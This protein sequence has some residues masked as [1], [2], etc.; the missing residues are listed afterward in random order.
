MEVKIL[1]SALI[2]TSSLIIYFEKR[3]KDINVLKQAEAYLKLLIHIRNKVDT[4]SMPI[5]RILDCCSTDIL[6]MCGIHNN[7]SNKYISLSSRIDD[8]AILL[9]NT[10]KNIILDFAS[11]FGS[12]YSESQLKICDNYI[13]Q[14]RVRIAEMKDQNKKNARVYLA[15]YLCITF[16]IVLILI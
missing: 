7:H 9:D 1:G 5:E 2:L 13:E 16:S 3:A 11:E 4:Y 12:A 10:T 14:L 15:L 6:N 8:G